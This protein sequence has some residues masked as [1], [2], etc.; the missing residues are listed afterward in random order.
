[1]IKKER[2]NKVGKKITEA[3]VAT[4]RYRMGKWPK[5]KK[6]PQLVSLFGVDPKAIAIAKR[7]INSGMSKDAGVAFF[8][9]DPNSFK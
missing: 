6:Q 5:W 2:R 1:M 3:Q 8:V 7:A 9:N 4:L